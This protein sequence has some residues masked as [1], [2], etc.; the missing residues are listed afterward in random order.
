M[1]VITVETVMSEET[2]LGEA[3][4]ADEA[5][6]QENQQVEESLV[7]DTGWYL[8][9]GVAGQGNTPDW[10]KSGKYK[11]VEDQAK[12]YL[13]LESKLGSFTGAPE[14]GYQVVLPEGMEAEIPDDDPMLVSFNDWAT[15]AGLSQDAHSKLLG[16]YMDNVIGSQPNIADEMKRIGPDA[17]SRITNV[18]EWAKNNL[19]EGEFGTLQQLATTADGFKL[20]ERMKSLGR[21]AQVSAPD[22]VHLS[23]EVTQESLYEL[24]KDERYQT[25]AVFRDDVERK[26]KDFYGTGASKE[27]RQ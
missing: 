7:E 4:V 8:S 2:L 17:Q 12:A 9:E 10:F 14:E 23:N 18:V 1:D 20:I 26:F 5:T 6:T 11:T 27:I 16:V 25:S 3:Q 22:T 21:E 13:G 24:I 15:E 19:D